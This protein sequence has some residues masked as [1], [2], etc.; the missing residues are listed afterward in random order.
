[1]LPAS[2][3]EKRGIVK[4]VR[5]QRRGPFR[6]GMDPRVGRETSEERRDVVCFWERKEVLVVSC[7]PGWGTQGE[8][9]G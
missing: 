1:M 8:P 3:R 5:E 9:P 2:Y 7:Y 6:F 4:G